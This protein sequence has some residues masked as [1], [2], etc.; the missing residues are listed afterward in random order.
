[1]RCGHHGYESTR[2]ERL[3]VRWLLLKE[4]VC[5][6]LQYYRPW[7]RCSDC[8]KRWGRHDEAMDHIPF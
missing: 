4:R 2:A 5:D 8:G 6:W 1:M 7:R 3:A